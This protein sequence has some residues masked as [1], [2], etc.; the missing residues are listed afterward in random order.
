MIETNEAITITKR[1]PFL[2]TISVIGDGF[3][4]GLQNLVIEDTSVLVR[5]GI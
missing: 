2:V 3:K 1:S 5:M 4:E